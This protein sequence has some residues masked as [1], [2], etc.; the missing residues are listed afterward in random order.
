MREGVN[1]ALFE[2]KLQE[3]L[4]T[5]KSVLGLAICTCRGRDIDEQFKKHVMAFLNV[6][7]AVAKSLNPK[8]EQVLTNLFKECTEDRP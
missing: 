7:F 4:A 1:M 3:P 6:K 8:C 2:N 5:L